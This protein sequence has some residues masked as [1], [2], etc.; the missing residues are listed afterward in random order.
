MR[1]RGLTFPPPHC[2]VKSALCSLADEAVV[3]Q[4]LPGN[5]LGR[6][7]VDVDLQVE[8]LHLLGGKKLGDR[9]K[10]VG[11]LLVLLEHVLAYGKRA[12]VGR[13]ELLVVLQK[14]EVQVGDTPIGG[15]DRAEVALLPIGDLVVD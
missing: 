3:A 2:W 6:L 4:E 8:L 13:E 9:G 12:V 5:L 11:E 15:E 10:Q 1:G 14:H 7:A